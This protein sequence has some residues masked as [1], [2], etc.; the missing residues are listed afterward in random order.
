MMW[1][2]VIVLVAVL[3]YVYSSEFYSFVNPVNYSISLPEKFTGALGVNNELEKAELL[4]ENALKWPE[5]FAV[6]KGQI[7]T[8]LGDGRIVSVTDKKIMEI[9]RTGKKCD[10]Q[11]EEHICGRPLGMTFNKVGTL[12]V[13]DAYLGLFS[14]DVKTGAASNI[15]PSNTKVDGLPLTFLNSLTFDEKEGALYITQS[16]TRWNI[17]MVMVSVLEHDVSGRLLK[18]D[19]KTNAVTVILKDLPFPNGVTLTHDRSA[20]LVAEG[21]NNKIFKYHIKGE[22]KGTRKQLP[23]VLPGEPDNITPNKRGNYWVGIATARTS[24]SPALH[25]KLS[26]KP[27]W[28][29]LLLHVHKLST[30]PICAVMGVLP[31][32]QSKEIGFELQSMRILADVLPSHGMIIEFDDTGKIVRSLHSP[33]GNV[34]HISEVL[35]HNG[36]LYLGSWRNHYIGRVKL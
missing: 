33:A 4:H 13:V 14:I 12:Y 1:N 6:Y 31:Y 18:Y 26:E 20:L 3:I 10:G 8:G 34:T 29:K 5:A 22:K 30:A 21:V 11:H 16:S 24:S 17:S 32:K 27:F 36:Y 35:E 28:R 25:D 9:S 19:L 23:L 7:Y 15:L 2:F